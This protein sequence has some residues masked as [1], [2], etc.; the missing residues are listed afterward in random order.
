M[1]PPPIEASHTQDN[2]ILQPIT[3]YH[4]ASMPQASTSPTSSP[5]LRAPTSH[6]S[7]PRRVHLNDNNPPT[8]ESISIALARLDPRQIPRPLRGKR[9]IL[10]P[11]RQHR[12][13]HR[14]RNIRDT[15][16]CEQIQT[17]ERSQHTRIGTTHS[18]T[19]YLHT[20]KKKKERTRRHR[21]VPVSDCIDPPPPTIHSYSKQNNQDTKWRTGMSGHL[22]T[23][24]TKKR[25][26]NSMKKK[27]WS[28]IIGLIV[29][30]VASVVAWLFSPK[31]E[32]QTYVIPLPSPFN[33]LL[34]SRSNGCL[35]LWRSTL[36]LSFVSCYLMWGMSFSRSF[37]SFSVSF[38]LGLGIW[39]LGWENE[40]ADL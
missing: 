17:T 31:G 9:S 5:S 34:G 16:T 21:L 36:I 10:P 32:N 22:L 26:T 33:V 15:S 12:F 35:R 24:K 3:A 20:Q 39:G 8:T 40:C 7:I 37:L 18:L 38:V 6:T 23:Q 19:D 4:P 29:I 11:R 28:L 25:K 13:P 14:W 30:A 1:Q 27:R 2:P